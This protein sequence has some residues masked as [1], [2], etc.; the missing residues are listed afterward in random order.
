NKGGLSPINR[1]VTRP[2]QLLEL[3]AQCWGRARQGK[4][5]PLV[6]A[7][8]ARTAVQAE[9]KVLGGV[10]GLSHLLGDPDRQRQVASQLAN[11]H[12]YADVA[13][14]QLYVAPRAAGVDGVSTAH[15]PVVKG[16]GEVVGDRL[17]DPLICAALVRLEDDGDLHSKR[18]T[19][20]SLH[21]SF[22]S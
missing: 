17:I 2:T 9:L 7:L 3:Q 4:V 1:R 22:E 18:N 15:S 8:A 19:A 11:D 12:G 20:H 14:V 21:E 5:P 13:S 6:N 16:C 10:I